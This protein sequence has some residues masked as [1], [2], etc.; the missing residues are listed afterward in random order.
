MPRFLAVIPIACLAVAPPLAPPLSAQVGA[1]P[2][3]S[4]RVLGQARAAQRAFEIRRR[5]LLPPTA[6]G[7]GRC[8]E[9]IGR[10]CYWYDEGDTTLPAEPIAIREA[11]ARFLAQLESFHRRVPGDDWLLGQRVR[12]LVEHG[13]TATASELTARCEAGRWWCEALAGFARHSARRFAEAEAAFDRA[14]AA[15]P[16]AVRCEWTDWTKVLDDELHGR[17]RELACGERPAFAD[18][19]FWLA[20]PRLTRPGNDLRTE[21][22][23]RRVIDWL[24]RASRSPQAMPW[25]K[26]VSELLMRYG[27]PVRWSVSDRSRP[28]L[29][30]ASVVGHDP[31]PA[32]TF[33]P[34]PAES[35]GSWRFDLKRDRPQSR[36]APAYTRFFNPLLRYQIARFPR[37]DSTVF[38]AA[39]SVRD[40]TAFADRAGTLSLALSAGPLDSA[41]TASTPLAG[42]AAV[43]VLAGP[44]VPMLAGLEAETADGRM[45]RARF[46]LDSLPAD[47][48]LV[49]SDLLLFE[50]HQLLPASLAEAAGRALSAP[51]WRRSQPIGVYW[52]MAGAGI[53]SIEV[54]VAVFPER[55]GILGRIGQSL[56]LVK[57]RVPLTLQWIMPERGDAVAGRAFEL[58]L[59]KLAPGSYTLVLTVTTGAGTER[60]T[61][62][63][64][65]L[66]K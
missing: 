37:G 18:S 57:R 49:L 32:F 24:L 2:T 43:L 15:M 13:D 6:I 25:G 48:S 33:F 38:V 23:S 40:D 20:A 47:S 63:G 8:D 46:V 36:Y 34:I 16:E 52:E 11:R 28:G 42:H 31:S 17:F 39:A 65:E 58:D 22:L 19:V 4:L 21:L 61:R 27:W 3:D 66:L 29:E 64:I 41:R 50:P 12:Y 45:A 7:S 56:S 26:D 55:R 51:R 1:D 62:R 14:L 59:S 54:A 30:P 35:T 44:R 5:D 60:T 10:F 53:D 9:R